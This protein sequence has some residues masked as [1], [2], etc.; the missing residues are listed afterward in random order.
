LIDGILR[1]VI[2][3]GDDV[4]VGVQFHKYLPLKGETVLFGLDA[5][6]C[7]A[8]RFFPAVSAFGVDIKLG[9]IG[10]VGDGPGVP[11]DGMAP[12]RLA[13]DEGRSFRPSFHAAAP[14]LANDSNV[15][16][17][18]SE[19][20]THSKKLQRLPRAHAK[21]DS[22]PNLDAIHDFRLPATEE[23]HEGGTETIVERD[24]CEIFEQGFRP[25]QA[26]FLRG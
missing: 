23:F 25:G 21:R 10:V 3:M 2:D 26:R 13:D 15:I 11:D 12:G 9:V 22:T 20:R 8:V 19:Q 24:V 5:C 4:L 6:P 16:P 1:A 17:R 7:V 18:R 14:P